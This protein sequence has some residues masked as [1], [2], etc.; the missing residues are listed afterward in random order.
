MS[1]KHL[2]GRGLAVLGIDRALGG[3]GQKLLPLTT[4]GNRGSDHANPAPR[5]GLGQVGE[6]CTIV[7][8]PLVGARETA[9]EIEVSRFLYVGNRDAINGRF[10][11]RPSVAALQ[12]GWQVGGYLF[13]C[14]CWGVARQYL[15]VSTD[16]ELGEVP[17][18]FMVA[19]L[20]WVIGLQE[21]IEGHG[22]VPVDLDFGEHRK[23]HVIVRGSELQDLLIGSRFLGSELVT[24]EAKNG[25]TG[26]LVVLVERTQTCVL[27]G[28]TSGTSDV[29]HQANLVLESLEADLVAGD[30]GHCQVMEGG[31]GHD[32]SLDRGGMPP[33]AGRITIEAC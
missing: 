14:S 10:S 7:L 31:H 24:G 4:K 5:Q 28:E 2:V 23:G 29:Y 11:H 25:E 3:I 26:S 15:T 19:I 21:L 27:R 16:E 13:G 1:R 12:V 17:C 9:S 22:S 6:G 18:E 8:R 20:V 33:A 32:P 30:R